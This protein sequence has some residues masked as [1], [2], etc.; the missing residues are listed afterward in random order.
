MIGAASVWVKPMGAEA[1]FR[2]ELPP[3]VSS[4]Y[5]RH[6]KRRYR[7]RRSGSAVHYFHAPPGT[8][9]FIS[10]YNR[11]LEGERI[12][13]EPS[14]LDLM[15]HLMMALRD[16]HRREV[17]SFVYAISDGAGFAKIGFARDAAKRLTS[18]QNGNPR[19]LV[20]LGLRSGDRVTE[21]DLHKRLSHARHAGEWF[22]E[23][24]VL[25]IMKWRG[26]WLT[27]ADLDLSK[28]RENTSK[29]ARY[30]EGWWARQDSR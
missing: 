13:R 8:P 1:D 9:E 2:R 24:A 3:Y 17:T 14:A 29:S 26:F 4:F 20:V 11:C 23:E 21:A 19:K 28:L 16:H 6:G 10:E 30:I 15:R 22:D 5:D 27:P 12:E 18:I 25:G 7:F